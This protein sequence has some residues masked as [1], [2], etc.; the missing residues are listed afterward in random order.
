MNCK[1][2][3]KYLLLLFV[4]GSVFSCKKDSEDDG[5]NLIEKHELAGIFIA[6]ITPTFMG[7]N[8]IASGEHTIHMEDVGN[9]KLRLHY[10][11]FRIDPMPFEMSVDITMDVKPG[12]NNSVLLEGT[13]GSFKASPPNGESIDPED[14]PGGIQLPPGAEG[15]LS[16]DQASITGTF[17]EIG[18]EGEIAWRYD[19]KLTPGV[20][21]PIQV[22]IYSKKKTTKQ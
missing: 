21:L 1:R 2:L 5:Q 6:Q 18:K 9:G 12:P 19:L 10:E 17:A 8:P 22:M 14:V 20:P 11:K 4:V 15:G 3:F 7:T 13:N 16:S